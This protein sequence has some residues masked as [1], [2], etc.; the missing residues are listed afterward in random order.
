M[1]YCTVLVTVLLL[2]SAVLVNAQESQ[3]NFSGEWMLNA[4]KSEFGEGRGGR[5][6]G[7]AAS[8]M[9]V[10]QENNKLVV[11]SFR[12][13]REGEEVSQ[14]S[15]YTLDGTEC[16]NESNFGSQVSWV[17]LSSDGKKIEFESTMTMSR[18]DREFIIESEEEWVLA[19]GVLTITS[20]RSTPRGEMKTIAVYEKAKNEEKNVGEE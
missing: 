2:M 11:E 13:N 1:K 18:G 8:K 4:D 3:E 5:R 6:F 15:T 10:Q 12:K 20:T 16:E 19:D 17:Y 7:M 9:V 14:E